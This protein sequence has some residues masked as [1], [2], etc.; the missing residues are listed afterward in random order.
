MFGE[1]VS[2]EMRLTDAGR[3]AAQWYQELENKFSD[4]RIDAFVVMPNPVHFIVVNTGD[5][6]DESGEHAGS[7]LRAVVQWFKTMTTNEYIRRVKTE[8]W[9]PFPGQLWQRNYYEHIIRNDRDWN[10]IRAYIR[11][12]PER[13]DQDEE[14]P[15]RND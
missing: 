1:I 12:N 4:I 11:E 15:L 7:P 2:G 13:W 3:M 6:T 10:R 14:N 9:R 8:G 5:G